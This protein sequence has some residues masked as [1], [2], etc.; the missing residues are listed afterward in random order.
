MSA[1]NRHSRRK[2]DAP[3]VFRFL[4]LH[5]AALT[6]FFVGYS[7]VALASMV[8]FYLIRYWGVSVVY[9]RYFS[10]KSFTTSRTFQ[11]ILGLIGTISGQ[12]GPLWWAAGHRKH[13]RYSDTE[14]D[15]HSPHNGSLF[16]SHIGWLLK[17]ES[18]ETDYDLVKDFTKYPEIMWLNKNHSVGITAS[19]IL[20]YVLGAFLESNYPGLGTSGWQLL[21]WGGVLSTLL[22]CHVV[23]GLNSINHIVGK[24]AYPTKDDSTNIWWMFPLMLGEHLHNNHHYFPSSHTAAFKGLETDLMGLSIKGMERLGLVSNV[25][26]PDPEKYLGDR[27][28]NDINEKSSL[29]RPTALN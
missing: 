18:L 29:I 14:L 10:H 22:C 28:D 27:I 7:H 11:F 25:K 13:H 16:H 21:V 12:R 9:H 15:V 19:F 3:S 5:L 24:K 2:I 1:D 17:K 6:V 26:K 20:L 8:I 4:I 23:L